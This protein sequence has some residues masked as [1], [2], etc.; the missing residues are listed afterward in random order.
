MSVSEVTKLRKEG[1]LQEA[2]DL[3]REELEECPDKWTRT[4]MFWV[5]R[6]MIQKVYLPANDIDSAQASLNEMRDFLYGGWMD[7]DEA[8]EQTYK[9][10]CKF[11]R[12]NGYV[13]KTASEQ[14]KTDP[15][16]AY[17][18]ITE[19]FGKDAKQL[20]DALHEDFGWIIYRY[21]KANF[22]RLTSVQIRCLLRDYMMLRNKRPSMLHSTILGFA[23]KFHKEHPDFSFYR[24]FLLWGPENLRKEDFIDSTYAVAHGDIFHLSDINTTI[25]ALLAGVSRE[26]Y[27]KEKLAKSSGIESSVGSPGVECHEDSSIDSENDDVSEISCSDSESSSPD[28]ES[29]TDPNLG[30]FEK[31]DCSAYIERHDIP[32]LISRICK[33]IW[34]SGEAFD[35]YG[36]VSRFANRY[37][38]GVADAFRR[39]YFWKLMDL[40]KED[41]LEALFQALTDYAEQYSGLGPSHWHSEILN[42]AY[43]C[44]KEDHQDE[45]VPFMMKWDGTGNFTGEDWHKQKG[46]DGVCYAPMAIRC[47]KRCFDIIK[48]TD[49]DMVSDAT[50]AWL[51]GL[52]KRV[53]E[54]A[55]DDDWSLRNYA[56]IC[57]WRGETEEAVD[58]YKSL[59]VRMS[60]TYYLWAEMA[61]L[62]HDNDDIAIGLLL[63]AKSLEKNEDFLGGIHLSL[64]SLLLQKGYVA[65]ATKEMD[66]YEAHRKEMRWSISDDF[67]AL[68]AQASARED[69]EQ[70]VDIES[71]ESMAEEFVYE[72]LDV[73]EFVITDKWVTDDVKHCSMTDG[74]G[75][76]CSVQ[77]NRFRALKGSKAGD[78]VQLRYKVEKNTNL[79]S[80]DGRAVT[81]DKVIPYAV[82]KTDAAAWSILRVRY[83]V[84][85]YVNEEKKVLHIIDSESEQVFFKYTGKP[86]PV[87]SLVRFREYK[88]T[89][90]AETRFCVAGVESCP[91]DEALQHM[92]QR[93][94]VVDDVNEAK[95]LFHVVLGK[96]VA[97]DVLRFDKRVVSDVVRF[98]QTDIRPKI[99]DLL[100]ITY[101]TRTNKEGKQR[102]KFLDIKTTEEECA[103]LRSTVRSWLKVGYKVERRSFLDFNIEDILNLD[104]EEDDE[105]DSKK[106]EP[107]FAFVGDYYVHRNL[108]RKYNITN[109]CEVCAKTVLCGNGKW[110]VYDLDVVQ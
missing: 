56:T 107:D 36:L 69:N 78:I 51:K 34:Y 74:K 97:I 38:S 20:D 2:Y 25:E 86:L 31:K 57:V 59:I 46:K 84:V 108:L 32:S 54:K 8:A 61:S 87:D 55:G 75:L 4:S 83:G 80:C 102:V 101:L 42:L 63:K 92:P 62:L 23:L 64:A 95:K 77:T 73:G 104:D 85:D 21:L 52:Y 13:V 67:Y 91:A 100:R 81:V 53:T 68:Q 9:S 43:R 82:R 45:F 70:S 90:K 29:Q 50:L 30:C 72:K 93:I 35:A 11:V 110:K 22:D 7:F 106:K 17:Q 41:K 28:G 99:G 88:D 60:R 44:M 39:M 96:G 98:D 6:D 49:K 14:S 66:A 58:L 89:R 71:Y 24:F 26:T 65:A 19:L 10:L 47:A 48:D 40:H 79:V 37:K 5:L 15:N 94:V 76:C 103:E 18:K 1:K 27:E 16:G 33:A 109:D 3:A 12:P 105:E